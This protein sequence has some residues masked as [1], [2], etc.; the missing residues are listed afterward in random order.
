MK[1][2]WEFEGKDQ[3]LQLMN[4][5]TVSIQK[6]ETATDRMDKEMRAVMKG[7]AGSIDYLNNRLDTLTKMKNSAFDPGQIRKFNREI[8]ATRRE[9][10]RLDGMGRNK[11]WFKGGGMSDLAGASPFGGMMS[12][13]SNPYVLAGAAV[14]GT[15]KVGWDSYKESLNIDKEMAKINATAKLGSRGIEEVEDKLFA[16]ANEAQVA[17]ETVPA[18]F[19]KILSSNGDLNKSLDI[20]KS[21]LK[22]AKANAADFAEVGGGVSQTLA[23]IGKRGYDAERVLNI[24][25][26]GKDFGAGEFSDFA[27]YIPQITALADGLGVKFEEV[28]ASYAFMTKSFTTEQSATLLQNTFQA[29]GKTDRRKALK[30]QLGVDV[31]DDKGQFRGMFA[32]FADI[33]KALDGLTDEQ[34]IKKLDKIGFDMQAATGISALS[35]GYRELA[36]GI[37][38]ANHSAGLLDE[39]LAKTA[40]RADDLTALAN[41]WTQFK[42]NMGEAIAPGL[43]HLITG[44]NQTLFGGK[45]SQYNK[46]VYGDNSGSFWSSL[47]QTFNPLGAN[48]S[49]V[50]KSREIVD[51]NQGDQTQLI[52]RLMEGRKALE[53]DPLR[54]RFAVD[55][56]G[57]EARTFLD[58]ANKQRNEVKTYFSIDDATFN[59]V[60]SKLNYIYRPEADVNLTESIRKGVPGYL[61]V[62]DSLNTKRLPQPSGK[63]DEFKVDKTKSSTTAGKSTAEEV[64]KVVA[65]GKQTRHV[66][67]NIDNLVAGGIHFTTNMTTEEQLKDGETLVTETLMRAVRDAEQLMDQGNG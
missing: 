66:T 6:M 16:M 59:D 22:A 8:D 30:K 63:V 31:F 65:G 13:A 27:R 42:N 54:I 20:S 21:S 62:L 17:F 51:A 7:G 57:A 24:F 3:L 23:I 45:S 44:A 37:D 29:L 48:Y 32:V 52:G 18:G 61:G 50:K 67:V 34:R 38:A 41:N 9:M 43:N 26:A 11:S 35:N 1:S 56:K 19:E 28:T 60:M 10:D 5:T 58:L 2:V 47:N 40:T 25:Q 46:Q 53:A 14:A 36:E 12:M 4:K 15:A 33:N 64:D 49:Y 55:A 39:T